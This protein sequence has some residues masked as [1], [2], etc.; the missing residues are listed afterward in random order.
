MEKKV[1]LNSWGMRKG[2]NGR[3]VKVESEETTWEQKEVRRSRRYG[4]EGQD[5]GKREG[6][7]RAQPEEIRHQT[8]W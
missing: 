3:G 7:K 6:C 4:V 2:R 5:S 8:P 1:N